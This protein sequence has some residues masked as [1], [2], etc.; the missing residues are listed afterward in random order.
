MLG[1]RTCHHT[2]HVI[3]ADDHVAATTLHSTE[4]LH[5]QQTSSHTTLLQTHHTP[6]TSMK[7][8]HLFTAW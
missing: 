4:F 5:D 7:L 2:Q 3:V 8:M 1:D 6:H